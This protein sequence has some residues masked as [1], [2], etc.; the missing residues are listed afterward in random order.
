MTIFEI[1]DQP[2]TP[3]G[4]DKEHKH[5]SKKADRPRGCKTF[6]IPTQLSTKYIL[7][8]NIKKMPTIVG[9]L[10]FISMINTASE[11]LK[12]KVFICRY[13]SVFEQLKFRAQLS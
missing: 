3:R 1:T 12:E 11:R 2:T 10:T 5:D 6:S 7:L 8:I 13:F 4:R 9:I